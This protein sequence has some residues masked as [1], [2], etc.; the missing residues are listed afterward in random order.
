MTDIVEQCNFLPMQIV[1][2][3]TKF[4]ITLPTTIRK[5]MGIRI[6]DIL[7]ARVRNGVVVLTAKTLV[8]REA[9]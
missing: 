8:D 4:Q 7:E 3:K 9:A 2:V 1:K 6:G 5:Q